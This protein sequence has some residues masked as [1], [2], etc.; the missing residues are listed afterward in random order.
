MRLLLCHGFIWARTHY[1]S[2]ISSNC[3]QFPVPVTLHLWQILDN[4][5]TTTTALCAAGILIL[6]MFP[7]CTAVFCPVWFLPA[8]FFCF[9]LS[10][11]FVSSCYCLNTN[12]MHH[13]HLQYETSACKELLLYSILTILVLIWAYQGSKG[14]GQWFMFVALLCFCMQPFSLTIGF[15]SVSSSICFNNPQLWRTKTVKIKSMWHSM[16]QT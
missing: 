7:C 10:C 13:F 8:L 15:Q 1:T 16:G 11:S 6:S 3:F 4:I 5:D 2:W 9:G 14:V 12:M